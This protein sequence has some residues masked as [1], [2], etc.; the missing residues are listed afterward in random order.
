MIPRLAKNSQ[1]PPIAAA[2]AWL[3]NRAGKSIAEIRST[4]RASVAE[5]SPVGFSPDRIQEHVEAPEWSPDDE[6]GA[7]VLVEIAGRNYA[8][9]TD[10]E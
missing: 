6:V 3:E 7:T 1:R 10:G 5:H 9:S 8:I 4:A 2:R